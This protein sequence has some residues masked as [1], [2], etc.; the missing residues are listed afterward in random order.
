ME[1]PG[2]PARI[3]RRNFALGVAS[4]AL[5]RLYGTLTDPSLVLT[6]FVSQL[7]A[8]PLVIGMLQPIAQGGWFLPQLLVSGLARRMP[9]K[10][11]L[12][13]ATA[14]GRALCWVM[15]TLLVWTTWNGNASW[16]LTVFLTVYAVY[17]LLSGGGGLSFMDI[18]AKAI[19]ADRRGSFFAWREFAGGV[20]ALAAGALTS[21]MLGA[22]SGLAFPV[23]F[24]S[25]FAVATLALAGGL[26]A[27][28]QVTEPAGVAI[29]E[30]SGRAGW[31]A[32]PALLRRDRNY[33]A[34]VAARILLLV[35]GV[36]RPFYTVFAVEKLAAP[37]SAAGAY[38]TG[39]TLA[40]VG[41]TILWG[42][43]SDRHGNRTAMLVASLLSIL[44]PLVPLVL[45]TRLSYVAFA[46]QFVVE[47]ALQSGI[48]VSALS[49]GLDLAPAADRVLYVGLLNTALGIVS[50]LLL[51]GGFVVER[52]GLDAVFAPS[53]ACAALSAVLVA[54][55]RDPRQAA[56][57]TGAQ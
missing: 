33:T 37:T 23:N 3:S 46:G 1:D 48:L 42:R 13:R 47:G 36:S 15:L 26:I 31:R 22:Q 10:M 52:W 30:H 25:L 57:S 17:A 20:L 39:F 5:F 45:G 2:L 9:R 49:L 14:L 18:V 27:F 6:W 28:A 41:S 50:L 29:A 21:Y 35:Q 11:P 19:G 12:Y 40:A 32:I 44:P 7:G 53:A 38:L 8:S 4:G 16:L 54:A 34:F 55:V 51:G 24:A 43:L 56:R